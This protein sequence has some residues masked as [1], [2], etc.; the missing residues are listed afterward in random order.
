M[1]KNLFEE[2]PPV[3]TKDWMVLIEKDLKGADFEKKLVWASP[4]GLKVKPFYRREDVASHAYLLQQEPGCFPF[5]RG[6][7]SL[8]NAWNICQA[9]HQGEVA[10]ANK[11]LRK[12]LERG[13]QSITLTSTVSENKLFGQK[14]CSQKDFDLLLK[15]FDF[16]SAE[17]NFAWGNRSPQAVSYLLNHLG[18]QGLKTSV[19]KGSFEFDPV[20]E[21]LLT[22]KLPKNESAMW[23]EISA[24][25]KEAKE[26]FPNAKQLVLRSSPLHRAG[27]NLGQDLAY[28]LGA[29]VEII[30]A[31]TKRGWKVE[32]VLALMGVKAEVATSY[33]MEIAFFRALRLL[34][35][36]MVKSYGV[37]SEHGKLWI[38]AETSRLTKTIYDPHVNIL[39]ESSEAM[40][41]VI[42]GVD[43][44]TVHPWDENF[45]QPTEASDRLARNTQL[46][47]REETGLSHCADAAAGSYYIEELT[48]KLAEVAWKKFLAREANGGLLAEI[49]S[50]VFQS[51]ISKA[52]EEL[53]KA[54]SS[55]RQTVLGSNQYPNIQDKMLA[56][57]QHEPGTV[58]SPE[59]LKSAEFQFLKDTNSIVA[60]PNYR[61]AED[62][63]SIRFQSERWALKHGSVPKVYCWTFGQLAF[64]KARASFCAN[65]YG[66]G[67]F[68]VVEGSGECS[69]AEHLSAIEQLKPSLVVF[70]SSDPEYGDSCP[71]LAATL[72]EKYPNIVRVVAGYPQDI[73]EKL[74]Q[75]G[76]QEFVH[77]K[78]DAKAYLKSCVE[79]LG[80]AQ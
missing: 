35:S 27:S 40:S 10:D 53:K 24:Y 44:L 22:G 54:V 32:E 36:A 55:R 7:N 50:G 2:F 75:A 20:G 13:A 15:G 80:G 21:M 64:R 76:I 1:T 17:I 60:L 4:E 46:V 68:E 31:L 30:D 71:E 33:F 23:D 37:A 12:A 62:F 43:V 74:Q 18:N 58:L 6:K 51:E 79:R 47:L 5:V 52:R 65:L 73:L 34:W 57:M 38:H 77:I 14:V 72:A 63:E 49:K 16:K 59:Q 67:G 78:T 61:L 41:A 9:I 70:C 28:I 48:D 45:R 56:Q 8:G 25:L 66:C 19:F 42:G 3:S 26:K 69:K 11:V 29:A 39:R